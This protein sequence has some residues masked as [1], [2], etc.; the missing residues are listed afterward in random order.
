LLATS[1][2]RGANLQEAIMDA[3]SIFRRLRGAVG[4]AVVWGAGW[5]ACALAV[6]AAMKVA[7]L[8]PASVIW[9]DAIAVAGRFGV[10]GGI[11]G[12]AFSLVI[13]LLYRGRRLS[14][15]SWV[16]FGT[17]G[18]VVAGLF[19]PA[20]MTVARLLSGDAF[21]PLEELLTSGLMAAAF[22]AVAAGG[23][24]RLAQRAQT[25]PPGP[26]QDQL[27]RPESTARLA[28]AEERPAWTARRSR[29]AQR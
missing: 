28:A 25:L 29:A 27:G 21:L 5:S 22:G 1:L 15:I 17:G 16:R 2:T 20:F 13:G 6:F 4:N 23:S 9:L 3:G 7:G 8:L 18:G 14:Q 10:M 26:D 19:V 12:G 24:L 11:V